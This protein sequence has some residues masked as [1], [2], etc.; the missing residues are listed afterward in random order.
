[1]TYNLCAYV[2]FELCREIGIQVTSRLLVLSSFD[3]RSL[4]RDALLVVFV[5]NSHSLFSSCSFSNIDFDISFF[6]FFF[7]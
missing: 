7:F 4:E 6:F 3:N 2:E 5:I 1:V